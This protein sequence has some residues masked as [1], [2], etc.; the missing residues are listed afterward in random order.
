MGT[1]DMLRAPWTLLA[2]MGKLCSQTRACPAPLC[3]PR[4]PQSPLASRKGATTP[5]SPSSFQGGRAFSTGDLGGF[6]KA[7]CSIYLDTASPESS[8]P[9]AWGWG[10]GTSSRQAAQS[11]P[12]GGRTLLPAGTLRPWMDPAPSAYPPH[13]WRT[14]PTGVGTGV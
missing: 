12:A 2:G 11:R 5:W 9:A 10:L 7:A 8:G 3:R 14:R 13:A 1:G 6:H 4:P